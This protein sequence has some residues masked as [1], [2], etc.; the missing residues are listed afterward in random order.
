[1]EPIIAIE[2]DLSDIS[3]E[4]EENNYA[5]VDLEKADLDKVDAIVISEQDENVMG[6][7]DTITDVPVVSA[8]SRSAREVRDELNKKFKKGIK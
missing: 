3:S 7:M 6:M 2:D 1:M 5:V 8:H 4:L